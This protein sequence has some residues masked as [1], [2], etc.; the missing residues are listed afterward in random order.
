LNDLTKYCRQVR[1]ILLSQLIH[2]GDSYGAL[3]EP[4]KGR[5]VH[6]ISIYQIQQIPYKV[7]LA[8]WAIY[9]IRNYRIPFRKSIV[10]CSR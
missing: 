1:E 7:F 8:E 5:A 6:Q 9:D 10:L 3:L 2:A 4:T